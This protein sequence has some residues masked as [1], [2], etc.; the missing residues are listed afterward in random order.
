MQVSAIM[1]GHREGLL[2]GPSISSF[3]DA[4]DHA[5]DHGM[6]VEPIIVL[7]RP[8]DLTQTMF[9]AADRWGAKVTRTD[10]GDPGLARNHGVGLASGQFV[11]FLD[12]DDLWSFN[13]LI[14]AYR[15]IEREE[16]P[17]IAHSELNMIFGRERLLWL[18]VDSEH[19]DFD[20]NYLQIGNYWDALSF[21]P[22]S[23]FVDIPFHRNELSSGYGHED[24]HWNCVTFSQGIPH[25]PVPDTVHMKRRRHGSQSARANSSDVVP[26]PTDLVRF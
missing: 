15:F 3:R 8:D 9:E 2:S 7:D 17:V 25:K 4:I 21:A 23:I 19:P 22:R 24:W 10:F 11:T 13:W 6:T 1:T 26:W 16:R 18:H 5:R 14:A 20:P 12:A